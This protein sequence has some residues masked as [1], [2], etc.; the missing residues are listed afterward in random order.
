MRPLHTESLIGPGSMKAAG[1]VISKLEL[2][3]A[4][5]VTDAV[6]CQKRVPAWVVGGRGVHPGRGWACSCTQ[7]HAHECLVTLGGGR[8][9]G[10]SQLCPTALRL[11]T[12]ADPPHGL[13]HMAKSGATRA[14]TDVLDS[15]GVKAVIFDGAMPNPTDLNVADGLALLKENN[16]DFVISFGGGSSHDCAKGIS[17][18]ATNGGRIHDYEG[19]DQ[20]K[21]PM[22]PLVS[23]N[24]TAGT[25]SEMTR[26]CIITDSARRVKMAIVDSQATPTIAVDDPALMVGMPKGL[27][28]ATGMDALTHAVEAY[29]STISNPVT[30]AHVCVLGWVGGWCVLG[31]RGRGECWLPSAG[32]KGE[33]R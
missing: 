23:V 30:G 7:S 12:T 10:I 28:A 29:M 2:K 3:K 20:S 11:T 19:V 1:S 15:I 26:F 8:G 13:Q 32:G 6:S 31:G 17:M 9:T 33:Q 24:T 16:C 27:T 22:L 5:I 4:L 18:V 14:V 21:V 25:A